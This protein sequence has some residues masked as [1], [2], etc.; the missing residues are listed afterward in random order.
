MGMDDNEFFAALKK[1]INTKREI[2]NGHY[3]V[4]R[5]E[6][7]IDEEPDGVSEF[8]TEN[9]QEIWKPELPSKLPEPKVDIVAGPVSLSEQQKNNI[10][11]IAYS[12]AVRNM[13]VEPEPIYHLWPIEGDPFKLARA[14][15]RPSIT[16]IQ[17]FLASDD[18]SRRMAERGID[19]AP[20]QGLSP[21]QIALIS[22]LSDPSSKLSFNA[23]LKKAGISWAKYNGWRRQKPFADAL[24]QGQGGVLHDVIGNVDVQL[25]SLAQ[26]GDLKSIIYFN[27]MVGRGPNNRKA[28]DAIQFAR[29]VLEAVQ[30]NVNPDQARAISAEIELASKQLGIGA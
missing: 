9:S 29:I 22:I 30:K 24:S 4:A 8:V 11:I 10:S 25:A 5:E 6:L 13:S 20:Q 26:N 28:V 19:V 27:E 12:L 2:R 23:R 16:G 18:Y 7:V 3:P 14:G 17:Q 15:K 21:E 1:E